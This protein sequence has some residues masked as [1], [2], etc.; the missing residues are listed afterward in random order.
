ML[1]LLAMLN[2]LKNLLLSGS[3]LILPLLAILND[4]KNL[5]LSGSELILPLLSRL[6]LLKNGLGF[7]RASVIVSAMI[8]D[9]LSVLVVS[10]GKN[11]FCIQRSD[12][13][14]CT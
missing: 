9:Y 10:F 2:D 11:I 8:E 7:S 6:R 3:E 13:A 1:P 12:A 5:L 4:L 14:L